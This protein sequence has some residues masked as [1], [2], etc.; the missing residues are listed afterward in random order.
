MV[1]RCALTAGDGAVSTALGG[2][3]E[4]PP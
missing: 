2:H 4:P 3:G 1:A